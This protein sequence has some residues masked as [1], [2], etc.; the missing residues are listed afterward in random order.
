MAKFA[1]R[2]PLQDEVRASLSLGIP[3]AFAQVTQASAGFVDTLMMGWLGAENLAAGG[4]AA[5]TFLN[6]VVT[7]LGLVYG[8]APLVAEAFGAGNRGRVQQLAR[9][10]LWLVLVVSLPVMLLLKFMDPVLHLLG[11]DPQVIALAKPYLDMMVWGFLPALAFDMLKGIVSS[12]SQVRSLMPIVIAGT[13]LNATGNYLLAFGPFGLP[14]FGLSGIALSTVITNWGMLMALIAA[15]FWQTELRKFH[16]FRKFWQF[17]RKIIWEMIRISIPI[18]IAFT[19]EV[20]LFTT[21]TYLMGILGTESLAAHQIVFQTIV[22][23]FMIPLGFAQATTVRVGQWLGQGNFS[24]VRRSAYINMVLG[25]VFMIFAA[26][27]LLLLARPIVGIY[28]DLNHPDNARIGALAISM[29]AI[30]A[31]SQICDGVQT[32]ANGALRGLQDT[33]MPM[34]LSLFSFWGIGLALGCF[35]G[36]V[37]HLGG[38]GLWIGQAIGVAT[39]AATYVWRFNQVLKQE[40]RDHA[41]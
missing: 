33:Q 34:L 15:L 27:G 16:L 25:G 20:G 14:Q 41:V 23:I 1:L 31:I 9:Q 30:A 29:F 26:I 39:A 12:L 35:L 4:L 2:S 36:F 22:L 7:S 5:T 13:L 37:C 8:V 38:M 24:G 6:L 19:L 3:L 10:A 32:N 11:Q 40:I 28:L 21:T 17:D 18:C